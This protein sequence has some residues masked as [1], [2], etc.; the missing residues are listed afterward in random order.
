MGLIAEASP[1]APLAQQT[2]EMSDEAEDAVASPLPVSLS[3]GGASLSPAREAATKARGE[4]AD[5]GGGDAVRFRGRDLPPVGRDPLAA[6]ASAA[7][8]RLSETAHRAAELTLGALALGAPGATAE[9]VVRASRDGLWG[10]IAAARALAAGAAA[11]AD[12]AVEGTRQ[13]YRAAVSAVEAAKE[14]AANGSSSSSVPES[15]VPGDG[16]AILGAFRAELCDEVVSSSSTA[17]APLFP[18]APRRI[19]GS[20]F[21][22]ST[23]VHFLVSR[24]HQSLGRA[25]SRA[26]TASAAEASAASL[27][28][29]S[30]E[31]GGFLGATLA[32]ED[33]ERAA[34][35]AERAAGL[36]VAGSVAAIPLGVIER[37]EVVEEEGEEGGSGGGGGRGRK[38]LVVFVKGSGN[39]NDVTFAEFGAPSDA[40]EALALVEYLL[41]EGKE[42]EAP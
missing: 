4:A 9:D 30:S 3:S 35:E 39:K 21:V 16:S 33:A 22:T 23:S 14:A 38:S 5:G 7:S 13:Q 2:N 6:A 15:Y 25:V 31:L 8:A 19:R 17:A 26:V 37:A 12:A 36:P 1:P 42:E 41:G 24:A 40:D 28:T 29:A 10:A 20:L 27:G 11:A 18:P 32:A 34:T